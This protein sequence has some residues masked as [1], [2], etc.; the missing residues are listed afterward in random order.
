MLY[1]D[2]IK[3]LLIITLCTVYLLWTSRKENNKQRLLC[4]RSSKWTAY[5]NRRRESTGQI[6]F[7]VLKQC[8][9]ISFSTSAYILQTGGIEKVL[10]ITVAEAQHS[11]PHKV[12]SSK[13]G[14]FSFSGKSSFS[15]GTLIGLLSVAIATV[16][17]LML[18]TKVL[19]SSYPGLKESWIKG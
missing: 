10:T 1:H 16:R 17:G 9:I 19:L 5:Y 13:S 18:L 6:S 8:I 12:S 15:H 2:Q 14:A 4:H 7:K 3:Y 11:S